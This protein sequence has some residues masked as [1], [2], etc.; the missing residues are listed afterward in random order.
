MPDA[1]G[2]ELLAQD[3]RDHDGD[4]VLGTLYF[5]ERATVLVTPEAVP[6]TLEFLRG[7]GF[8]F[9]ASVHGLDYWPVE[10]VLPLSPV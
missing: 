5:R 8:A 6:G 3:L 4:G 9:L 1:T 10:D 7:R 2:L